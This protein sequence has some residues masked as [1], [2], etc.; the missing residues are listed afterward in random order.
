MCMFIYLL[1]L[2]YSTMVPGLLIRKVMPLGSKQP[3]IRQMFVHS[4]GLLR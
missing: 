2:Y 3:A 4:K 1:I